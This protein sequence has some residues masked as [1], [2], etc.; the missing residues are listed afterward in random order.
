MPV[1]LC[2]GDLTITKAVKTWNGRAGGGGG[3]ASPS[4]LCRVSTVREVLIVR[5]LY[6]TLYPQLTLGRKGDQF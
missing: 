5:H 4:V 6:L 3:G 1:T 2:C